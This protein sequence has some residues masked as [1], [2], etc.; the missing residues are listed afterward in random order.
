MRTMMF[1]R[2]GLVNMTKVIMEILSSQRLDAI[3]ERDD[4]G[5]VEST[6]VM[7]ERG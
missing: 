2:I 4:C 5:P 7:E 1:L 3:A 6:A